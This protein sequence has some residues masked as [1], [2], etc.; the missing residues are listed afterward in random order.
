[1]PTLEQRRARDT[2]NRA[3]A[4]KSEM[5]NDFSKYVDAAKSLPALIMNS[6]LMQVLAFCHEKGQREAGSHYELVATHLRNWL[7]YRFNG[8]DQDPGF[9]P[10][11]QMLM[12]ADPRQ[13]QLI[14]SEAF[15]WLRWMRQMAAAR[16]GG[17]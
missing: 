4:M 12:R 17:E 2:W 6:G 10:F 3:N 7:N 14:T 1:M 15:E 16:K 11:M 13:F 5:G 9:E 8:D